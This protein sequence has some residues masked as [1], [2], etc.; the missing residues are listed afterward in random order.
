M[1]RITNILFS[2]AGCTAVFLTAPLRGQAPAGVVIPNTAQVEYDDGAGGT[3]TVLSDTVYTEIAGE[4]LFVT[5]TADLTEAER[6]DFITYSIQIYNRSGTDIS[7]VTV[8]DTLPGMLSFVSASPSGTVD[9]RV[10]VWTNPVIAA[11]ELFTVTVTCRVTGSGYRSTIENHVIYESSANAPASSDTAVV[12]WLPWPDADL[13]K[14]VAPLQVWYGDTLTYTLRVTNTGYM[15]LT[16][17]VVADTIP[18]GLIFIDSSRPVSVSGGAASFSTND[19]VPPGSAVRSLASGTLTSAGEDAAGAGEQLLSWPLPDLATGRTETLSYR[20][21]VTPAAASLVEG[22]A[23]LTTLQGVGD[24]ASAQAQ[25]RGAGAVL[26]V[27]KLTSKSEYRA[28]ETVAFYIIVKNTGTRSAQTVAVQDTL[29]SSLSYRGSSHGGS[30]ENGIVHWSLGDVAPGV[31]DTLQVT[32][33]IRIPV[34]D[35]ALITNAV[36]A[37]AAYGV[38]D[39]SSSSFHVLS[40]PSVDLQLDVDR[41]ACFT[42]D[43]LIYTLTAVN[44]GLTNLSD[45]IIE[46]TLHPNQQYLSSEPPGTVSGSSLLWNL[47]SLDYRQTRSFSFRTV[48]TAGAAG[49]SIPNAASIATAEGA[50]DTARVST[51]ILGTGVGIEII[52]E[53]ADTLFNARDTVTW[54]LILSNGGIRGSSHVV[55]RDT[56]PSDLYF[57]GATHGGRLEDN[58]V[59]WDLDEFEPGYHDTLRVSTGIRIPIDDRTPVLN[60]VWARAEGARDSSD[61][62]IRVESLPDLR[63]WILGPAIASPGDTIQYMLIYDNIGTSTSYDPVLKDTLPEFLDFVNASDDFTYFPE[64]DAVHWQLPSIHPGDKD[65]LYLSA[66]IIDSITA[67]DEIIN[68]AW[69]A[70]LQATRLAIATCHTVTPTASADLYTY[71]LVDHE[72]ASAGDTLIYT[73]RY[74][75]LNEAIDDTLHIIDRLPP[76]LTMLEEDLVLKTSARL[77]SYDPVSNRVHFIQVGLEANAADSIQFKTRVRQPLSPGE[78]WIENHAWVHTGSDT[79]RTED[80]P[81]TRSR[82]QLIAPFLAVSK[83]VNRKVTEAGDVLTYTLII[84]NKSSISSAGEVLISDLLPEGFRYQKGTSVLDSTAIADPRL[85]VSGD[86][87]LMQWS[88]ADSLRP[89]QKRQLKYRVIVGLGVTPGEHKNYVTVTGVTEEGTSVSSD[90]AEAAVLVRRGAF[91]ER[92]FIFGKVFEDLN[93]NGLHDRSEPVFKDIELIMEDGTRVKTDAYGKYSIPDVEHGQHVLRFNENTLPPGM[94]VVNT[95][96][97]FLGDPK[98]RLVIVAPGSMAKANFI[99]RSIN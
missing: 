44:T 87:P 78:Q 85:A 18:A 17:P 29:P 50:T 27:T 7:G 32:A 31:T 70:Y 38:K 83:S 30:A 76:E 51:V 41:Q 22:T 48:V 94:R 74:G 13:E 69:L 56:L 6:G 42:G 14:T 11:K 36:W 53:A 99:V 37:S 28:D 9:G 80:D 1:N 57:I 4:G 81:R 59:I 26:N 39:S 61:W 89:L 54:D 96:I 79:V 73:I 52:K 33:A 40:R 86:R 2:I 43:T 16:N 93:G 15:T 3:L 21:L 75:S 35:G 8:R 72:Q 63:L 97:A 20:A 55:I 92:G 60:E 10:V 91:D 71:K 66:R 49:D 47:G 98:S 24:R 82:T 19:P 77:L 62:L 64:V 84:E 65:T 23:T 68:S 67:E 5:K 25:V 34:A 88:L 95:G 45:V 58:I 46:D 12:T 90:R